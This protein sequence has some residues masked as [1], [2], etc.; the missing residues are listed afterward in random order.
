MQQHIDDAHYVEC[1]YCDDYFESAEERDIHDR[2]VHLRFRCPRSNCNRLFRAIEHMQQH[3]DDAHYFECNY[4]DDYFESAEER[5][6]HDRRVHLRFRCP[7]PNCNILFR[8]IEHMQQ[9]IDDAHYFECDHCDDYFGSAEERDIH[10]RRVHLRFRCPRPNCNILFRAIEH[11]QQHIDDAHY[12]E[13][14]HCD[15]YFGSVEERDIHDRR[16]H[17]RFECPHPHC[18]RLFRANEHLQQHFFAKH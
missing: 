8:A 4:C 18:D 15:D 3:I 7:R 10:D 9:H 16:V 5:D 11:M 17:L 1:N 13:C 14:N 6:I 12:F 2:R